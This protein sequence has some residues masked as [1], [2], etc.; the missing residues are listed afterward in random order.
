MPRPEDNPRT[1]KAETIR[2]LARMLPWMPVLAALP[3][4]CLA[5]LW[6]GWRRVGVALVFFLPLYGLIWRISA[7]RVRPGLSLRVLA[8][9]SVAIVIGVVGVREFV[10]PRYDAHFLF[11]MAVYVVLALLTAITFFLPEPLFLGPPVPD[12]RWFIR[13]NDRPLPMAEP[14]AVQLFYGT[15]RQ[16]SAIPGRYYGGFRGKMAYGRC[17]VSI[18]RT[19]TMGHLE[20]P[21]WL[22]LQFREDPA[23]HIVIVTEEPYDRGLWCWALRTESE[24]AS[25]RQVLV[26]VHG[27]NVTFTK[28]ARLTAQITHD[29]GFNGTSLFYSWPSKG[30]ISPYMKDEASIQA[31]EANL[32][33]FLTYA[34]AWTEADEVFVLAHSMGNRAVT[35]VL[36]SLARDEPALAARVRH[37]ILAA[38]D[39]DAQYFLNSVG[40]GL[41][42]AGLRATL[43][44]SSDDVALQLSKQFHGEQRAGDTMPQVVVVKGITTIDA[45]GV[46]TSFIGHSRYAEG[47]SILSDIYYLMNGRDPADRFGLRAAQSPDGPYFTFRP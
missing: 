16:R 19:H 4:F 27:Y 15:D 37:V 11:N 1:G 8:A 9:A 5:A 40:P 45:S 42:K 3:G 14:N 38:P 29:L 46:D 12:V 26:F 43:Y 23:R 13:R 18:P 17:A 21:S 30:K 31:T 20:G 36:S 6:L 2:M 7:W 24:L 22:R 47:R 25:T 10:P 33:E 44:A 34:L 39:I 28:A 41:V 35:H 32:R